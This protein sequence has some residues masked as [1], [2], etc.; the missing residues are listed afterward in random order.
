MWL[1]ENSIEY[2]SLKTFQ[3][4]EARAPMTRPAEMLGLQRALD[5]ILKSATE[6]QL[7]T[8]GEV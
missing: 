6:D 1:N 3:T 8:A 5:M 2:F 4:Y 7:V